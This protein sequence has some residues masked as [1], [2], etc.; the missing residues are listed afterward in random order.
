MSKKPAYMYVFPGNQEAA[1]TFLEC[2]T[3][4]TASAFVQHPLIRDTNKRDLEKVLVTGTGSISFDF[5]LKEYLNKKAKELGG[6]YA[7][8]T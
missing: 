5:V 1:A 4:H 3:R 8:R 2:A 6:A 7:P